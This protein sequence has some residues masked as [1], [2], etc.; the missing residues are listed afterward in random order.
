MRILVLH[1][2]HHVSTRAVT[3]GHCPQYVLPR[4]PAALFSESGAWRGPSMFM[5]WQ[6]SAH[7]CLSFDCPPPR[8]PERRPKSVT[9]AILLTSYCKRE[10]GYVVPRK[11]GQGC[12]HNSNKEKQRRIVGCSISPNGMQNSMLAACAVCLLRKTKKNRHR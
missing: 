6:A 1:L 10:M 8:P 7:I 5:A 2:S 4:V 3:T 12:F 11:Q 9:L